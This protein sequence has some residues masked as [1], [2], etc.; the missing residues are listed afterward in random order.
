MRG[1]F[2]MLDKTWPDSMS[3]YNRILM[4]TYFNWRCIFSIV[5]QN[6]RFSLHRCW[7]T[8]STGRLDQVRL[9]LLP[10]EF[11]L[12]SLFM[13]SLFEELRK[14]NTSPIIGYYFMP[15]RWDSAYSCAFCCSFW[16][17]L[18]WISEGLVDWRREPKIWSW[19]PLNIPPDLILT[20]RL[21]VLKV[22]VYIDKSLSV[23]GALEQI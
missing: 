1:R 13:E 23:T 9:R 4:E 14:R 12:L 2:I 10:L 16:A 15:E 11:A 22:T 20:E 19:Q 21:T 8:L 17:Y 6:W 18:D 3:Y 5:W 7:G